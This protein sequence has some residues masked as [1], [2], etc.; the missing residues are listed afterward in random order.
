M[1]RQH[2]PAGAVV[3]YGDAAPSRAAVTWATLE[4]SLV[5]VGSRERIGPFAAL[6]RSVGRALAARA[7]APLVV[8][9]RETTAFLA[10][11]P[12]LEESLASALRR[13]PGR[14][15]GALDDRASGGS[16]V[17]QDSGELVGEHDR[18]AALLGCGMDRP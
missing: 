7:Q 13:C 12:G 5:V 6:R 10:R 18:D 16:A 9:G 15:S 3:G 8:V 4:A 2:L 1:V 17:V 11:D 14:W